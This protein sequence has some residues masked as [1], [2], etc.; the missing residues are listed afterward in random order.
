[1]SIVPSSLTTPA[2][3]S[4]TLAL[5]ERSTRAPMAFPPAAVRRAA[6]ACALSSDRPA[7]ATSAP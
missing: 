4:S 2:A 5:L 6:M 7:T 1:M 3:N